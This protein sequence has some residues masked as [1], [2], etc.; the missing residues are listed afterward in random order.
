MQVSWPTAEVKNKKQLEALCALLSK[1]PLFSLDTET[2]GEKGESLDT[3][4][5]II[6]VGIPK[7]KKSG[8][9]DPNRGKVFVVDALALKA[10][11]DAASLKNR[12]GV[13]I[14][15]LA[16]LKKILEASETEEG[17][18]SE[19]LIHFAQFEQAQFR[20]YGIEISGVKDTLKLAKALR[21]ELESVALAACSV[22]FLGMSLSKEEQTSDW[23]VR[24]LS[25]SQFNYAALDAQI[26]FTLYAKLKKLEEGA[27]PRKNASPEELIEDMRDALLDSLRVLRNDDVGNRYMTSLVRSQKLKE[28]L[29]EA[30][31]A[32]IPPGEREYAPEEPFSYGSAS[33][34]CPDLREL[35]VGKFEAK[36]PVVAEEISSYYTATKK[37]VTEALLAEVKDAAKAESA[38]KQIFRLSKWTS[39]SLKVKFDFRG[40]Y[41][42]GKS[43]V[44]AANEGLISGSHINSSTFKSLETQ[45]KR[46]RPDLI[47][48]SPEALAK[49]I[50]NEDISLPADPQSAAQMKKHGQRVDQALE[51]LET[52][53]KRMNDEAFAPIIDDPDSILRELVVEAKKR[54]DILRDAGVG[55]KF[56]PSQFKMER[57]GEELSR[58]LAPN[59][60]DKAGRFEYPSPAGVAALSR[61]AM[62]QIDVDYFREEYPEAARRVLAPTKTRITEALRDRGVDSSSIAAIFKEIEDEAGKG[63]PR[64]SCYPKYKLLYVPHSES[65]S[66]MEQDPEA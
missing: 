33:I 58:L 14:N 17:L 13:V 61:R 43:I 12:D 30:L 60:G 42:D 25:E 36:L 66:P 4:L 62:P 52:K 34:K 55:D 28:A 54:S 20:K 6:Q 56:G 21:P 10:E 11:A 44:A 7:Y 29:K 41:G 18:A 64:F 23:L 35:N 19:K 9:I 45:A 63:D 3:R 37:D 2:G 46:V 31:S 24:P 47:E 15:P 1:A 5:S 50:L 22:E 8:E 38:V 26:L 65:D 27:A 39:P 59:L 32:R 40:E 48:F 57:A 49:E 51:A 53:L 16:P